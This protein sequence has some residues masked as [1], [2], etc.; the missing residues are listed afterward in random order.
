[1]FTSVSTRFAGNDD[2][3]VEICKY[4]CFVDAR[5]HTFL[6]VLNFR[7]ECRFCCRSVFIVR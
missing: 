4:S 1:M 2:D 6:N 3:F 5:V 7:V